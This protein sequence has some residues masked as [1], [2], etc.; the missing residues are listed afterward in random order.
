[1]RNKHIVTSFYVEHEP[2]TYKG[3]VYESFDG[4]WVIQREGPPTPLMEVS[5][6]VEVS[7]M[8]RLPWWQLRR[9]R[10]ETYY[11]WSKA[12]G[13]V[14]SGWVSASAPQFRHA[15]EL[16]WL[17]QQNKASHYEVDTSTT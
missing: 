8:H 1:M 13:K 12:K 17:I 9:R 5:G 6:V 11:R 14:K 7:I 3:Q 10:S 15:H 2:K 16:F 4:R